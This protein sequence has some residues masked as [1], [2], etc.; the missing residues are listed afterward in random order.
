MNDQADPLRLRLTFY[1]ALAGIA[2]VLLALI[3]TLLAFHS[4][5]N[6]G[7]VIPAVIGPVTAVVGTLAG[8]VAGQAAGAAGKEKAEQ[9]AEAA[10]ANSAKVE[11]QL[12]AVAGLGS[13]KTGEDL[14]AQARERFPD[15]FPQVPETGS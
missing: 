8:Y 5:S 15:W 2:A 4:V 9:R 14:M 13:A 12:G 3:A 6:P 10:T 7:E 11:K 1:I